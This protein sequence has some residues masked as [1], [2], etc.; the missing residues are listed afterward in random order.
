MSKEKIFAL[1]AIASVLTVIV[2]LPILFSEEKGLIPAAFG[3]IGVVVG[4]LLALAKDWWSQ[5]LKERKEAAYLAALVSCELDRFVGKCAAV[6]ADDGLCY[7]AYNNEGV[8]ERQVVPPTF[9]PLTMAVEWKSLPPE[10]M[11]EILDLP[12]RTEAT[13]EFV[14]EVFDYAADPPDYAEAFEE[15]QYRYAALGIAVAELVTKLR[16]QAG[17]PERQM[18]D[19]DPVAYMKTK[20]AEIEELRSKRRPSSPLLHT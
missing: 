11:D 20:S 10:L 2:G 18:M 14:C 19:W 9:S 5:R 15:R 6:A 8:R 4:S 13:G 1:L 16:R 7:G 12:R 17:L 3:L